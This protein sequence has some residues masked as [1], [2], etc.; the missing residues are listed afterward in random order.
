MIKVKYKNL[1]IGNNEKFS[2]GC[3]HNTII[4]KLINRVDIKI[5]S[6]Y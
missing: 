5:N 1:I 3:V 2:Y 4:Y 6:I